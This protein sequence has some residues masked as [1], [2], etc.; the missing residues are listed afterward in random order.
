LKRKLVNIILVSELILTTV[1]LAQEKPLSEAFRKSTV[2]ETDAVRVQL[3]KPRVFNSAAGIY[4][5]VFYGQ[6]L[7]LGGQFNHW[8]QKPF[9]FEA[10]FGIVSITEDRLYLTQDPYL[11]GNYVSYER[12]AVLFQFYLGVNKYLFSKD[13]NSNFRFH[14]TIGLGPVLGV[15]YTDRNTSP[16]S[17][18]YSR[19][20]WTFS[21]FTGIKVDYVAGTRGQLLLNLDIR[22]YLLRFRQS[23]MD[24]KN[25]DGLVVMFGFARMF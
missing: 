24:K 7:G 8:L 11:Y 5:G 3:P 9:S 13:S 18:H 19:T 21:E 2:E 25:Y 12:S 15:E 16:R 14:F 20:I 10:D 23:I 1:S 22:Y 6:F 4:L 17:L